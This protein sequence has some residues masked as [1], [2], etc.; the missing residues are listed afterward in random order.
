MKKA[1]KTLLIVVL[2]LLAIPVGL[3][4]YYYVESNKKMHFANTDEARQQGA[5]GDGLEIPEGVLPESATD[6]TFQVDTDTQ[7]RWLAFSFVGQQALTLSNCTWDAT[8]DVDAIRG[9]RWWSR[10]AKNAARN[11]E[12]YRCADRGEL[13]GYGLI[14]DCVLV[15]GASSGAWSCD[16]GRQVPK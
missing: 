4:T 14:Y 1:L 15:I 11:A 16:S 3:L 5:I 2:A 10:A 8:I 9:P 7:W 13:P 6:I 12:K